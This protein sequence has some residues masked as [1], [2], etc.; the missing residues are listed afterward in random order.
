MIQ[1]IVVVRFLA[2]ALGLVLSNN[3][4]AK[5]LNSKEFGPYIVYFNALPTE[6]LTPEIAERHRITRS[7]NRI[8]LNIVVK[9]KE[10][11]LEI[12][13]PAEVKAQVKNLLGQITT[14]EVRPVH[15]GSAIY[16]LAE[17]NVAHRE[18]LHFTLE[19]KPSASRET[20]VVKFAQDFYTR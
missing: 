19:I 2:C 15:E 20:F 3:I 11:T 5:E 1:P 8:L 10:K 4:L 17:F 18:L 7:R 14:A 6:F 13:T 12:A 16:Y 9:T